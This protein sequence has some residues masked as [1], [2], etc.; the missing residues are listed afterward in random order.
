MQQVSLHGRPPGRSCNGRRAVAARRLC[1]G[2]SVGARNSPPKPL[3]IHTPHTTRTT[4]DAQR[5]TARHDAIRHDATRRDSRRDNGASVCVAPGSPTLQGKSGRAGRR[6]SPSSG[7]PASLHAAPLRLALRAAPPRREW[8][9]I[10]HESGSLARGSGPGRRRARSPAACA[11]VVQ[12]GSSTG[13]P[14]A[15][16]V[17]RGVENP[18]GVPKSLGFEPLGGSERVPQPHAHKPRRSLRRVALG[19]YAHVARGYRSPVF[20]TWVH[21]GGTPSSREME[22]RDRRDRTLLL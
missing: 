1:R 3:P 10:L 18:S 19:T 22:G 13:Y 21:A 9:P 15:R 8:L 14:H 5:D 12:G 20:V 17:P 4:Q 2:V 11:A 7:P 16:R 6:G